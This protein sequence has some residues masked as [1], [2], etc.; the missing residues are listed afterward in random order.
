MSLCSVWWGLVSLTTS[1]VSFSYSLATNTFKTCKHFIQLWDIHWCILHHKT[2]GVI[3]KVCGKHRPYFIQLKNAQW[4]LG[5]RTIPTVCGYNDEVGKDK[6]QNKLN[7]LQIKYFG[8]CDFVSAAVS[9][10][11]KSLPQHYLIGNMSQFV[12]YKHWK[13]W[14]RKVTSK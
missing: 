6:Y 5:F 1:V 9:Y 8:V 14:I 11:T 7:K 12:A 13:I 10:H 2:K 3:S 4:F